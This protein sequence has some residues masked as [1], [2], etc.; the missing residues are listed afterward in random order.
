MHGWVFESDTIVASGCKTEVR[1]HAV[2][3]ERK[4][5]QCRQQRTAVTHFDRA[6]RTNP[7]RAKTQRQKPQSGHA[8]RGL[9]LEDATSE[10]RSDQWRS[11]MLLVYKS[12]TK[13]CP[14]RR[15][16]RFA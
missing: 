4:P 15:L 1:Y 12:L 13:L 5:T 3:Q 8:R 7:R 16:C 14:N 9:E 2:Q 6:P 11:L 10:A